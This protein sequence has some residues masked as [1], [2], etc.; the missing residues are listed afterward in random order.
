MAQ[1]PRAGNGDLLVWRPGLDGSA[2]GTTERVRPARADPR[3]RIARV[4]SDR[5]DRHG[6]ACEPVCYGIRERMRH[7]ER[8]GSGRVLTVQIPRRRANAAA[9]RIPEIARLGDIEVLLDQRLDNVQTELRFN[10]V[11]DF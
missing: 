7:T 5:H 3:R 10:G 8:T 2:H 9:V 11:I 6:L 4:D 1:P